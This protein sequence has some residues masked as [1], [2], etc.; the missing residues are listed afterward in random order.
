MAGKY[1]SPWGALYAT[2]V[3]HVRIHHTIRSIRNHSKANG[4]IYSLAKA[5]HAEEVAIE[6][7]EDLAGLVVDP[8][9]C[10]VVCRVPHIPNKEILLL[11]E[12]GRYRGAYMVPCPEL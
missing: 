11:I 2:P 9:A 3:S 5:W 10:N 7:V 8:N 4:G 6:R 12:G 1:L